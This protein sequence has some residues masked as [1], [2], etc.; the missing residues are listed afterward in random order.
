MNEFASE[1]LFREGA[2]VEVRES[3]D[4][5]KGTKQLTGQTTIY[6]KVGWMG[7]AYQIRADKQ[8]FEVVAENGKPVLRQFSTGKTFEVGSFYL[9]VIECSPVEG[10]VYNSRKFLPNPEL[11]IS[12][13]PLSPSTVA[14]AAKSY[15][16]NPTEEKKK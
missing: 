12:V 3:A 4:K 13:E 8:K 14:P 16:M 2:L 9:F 1:K 15:A 5:V 11:L 7:G 10:I 6:V